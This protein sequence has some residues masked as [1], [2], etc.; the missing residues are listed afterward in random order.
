MGIAGINK[1]INEFKKSR[2][3]VIGDIMLDRYIYGNVHRISSEAPVPVVEVEKEIFVLGGVGNVA[4][5]LRSLGAEAIVCSV[6]GSD[7]IGG[8]LIHMMSEQGLDYGGILIDIN[9]D[10]PTTIKTRIVGNNSQIVRAD[11]ESKEKI[12]RQCQTEIL[13]FVESKVSMVDS[14]IISDHNNGIITPGLVNDMM[15]IVKREDKFIASNPYQDNFKAHKSMDIITS[16]VG[17][18]S[19]YCGF[20]IRDNKSLRTAANI[21]FEDLQCGNLLVTRGK[22]GMA[23]FEYQA[24]RKIIHIPTIGKRIFDASGVGDTVISALVLGK[25]VGMDL[26]DAAKLSNAAAGISVSKPGT[27]VVTAEELSKYLEA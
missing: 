8:R 24:K 1:Y 10:R 22:A 21:I 25:S 7:S 17:D 5:N 12:S 23:L 16:S 15:E 27:A 6:I 26:E 3:L 14:V 18:V 11:N 19:H 4:N 20:K 13:S 9:T 2:I